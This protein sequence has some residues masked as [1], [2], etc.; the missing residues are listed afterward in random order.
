MADDVHLLKSGDA[1]I[2]DNG[3]KQQGMGAPTLAAYDPADVKVQKRVPMF[4]R[5]VIVTMDCQTAGVATGTDKLMELEIVNGFI[6]KI[7]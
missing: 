6:I 7:L 4:D 5:T 3:R 1:G 2:R